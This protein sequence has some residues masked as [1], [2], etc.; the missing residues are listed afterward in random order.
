MNNQKKY[1]MV[2]AIL[3]FRIWLSMTL[4]ISIGYQFTGELWLVALMGVVTMVPRMFMASIAAP[5]SKRIGSNQLM[6]VSLVVLAVFSAI[7]SGIT[8]SGQLNYY[9]LLLYQLIGGVC[10][11]LYYPLSNSFA[12]KVDASKKRETLVTRGLWR[13]RASALALFI[14]LVIQKEVMNDELTWAWVQILLTILLAIAAFVQK[15]ILLEGRVSREPLDWLSTLRLLGRELLGKEGSN[16]KIQLV[17]WLHTTRTIFASSFLIFFVFFTEELQRGQEEIL[18]LRFSAMFLS[19]FLLE[20]LVR[21][22]LFLESWFQQAKMIA[23]FGVFASLAFTS[24]TVLQFTPMFLPVLL[25]YSVYWLIGKTLDEMLSIR[26][27]TLE[28]ESD[29]LN[30]FAVSGLIRQIAPLVTFSIVAVL[31]FLSH[32]AAVQL[33]GV[34]GMVSYGLLYLISLR[35]EKLN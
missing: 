14:G 23:L 20:F 24:F 7:V 5:L 33:M 29:S 27:Q 6:S 30:L 10:I 3:D 15:T 1:F 19:V 11:A 34:S 17:L 12:A 16:S 28:V 35:Q 21:N 31:G 2:N 4:S 22:S 8:F 32:G 25:L 13:A 9:W 18:W 26:I